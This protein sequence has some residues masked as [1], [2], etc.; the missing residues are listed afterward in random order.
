MGIPPV[1]FRHEKEVYFN[2][3]SKERTVSITAFYRSVTFSYSS[4]LRKK[5]K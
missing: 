2:D 4:P 1:A 5:R 3:N